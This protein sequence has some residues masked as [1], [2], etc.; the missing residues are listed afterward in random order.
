MLVLVIVFCQRAKLF[1]LMR[2]FLEARSCI[3]D[4]KIGNVGLIRPEI[5]NLNQ[6]GQ[7]KNIK[8]F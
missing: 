2:Y 8:H 6:F 1:Q 7:C 4:N 3:K 5:F